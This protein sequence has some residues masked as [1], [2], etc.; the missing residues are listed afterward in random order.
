MIYCLDT[1]ICIYFLLGKYPALLAK[2]MQLSSNDIKI[3]AIVKAELLLGAEKS[4]RQDDNRKKIL[5]FLLPFEIVPFDDDA[6]TH[7]S[8]IRAV[9]E[10]SGRII[11]PNDLLIAATVLAQNA[12]LVTNNTKEFSRVQGLPIENWIY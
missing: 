10:Q 8:K 4:L 3:P 9:L 6:A 2:M 12:I 7:Y 11:G 1:N 5:S